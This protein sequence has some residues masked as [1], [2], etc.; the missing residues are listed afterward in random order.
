[1]KILHYALGFP[2]ERT[3]GLV[4]YSLDLINSQI[5]NGHEV[6]LMYPGRLNLFHKK[7]YL[8]FGERN[9]IA[10]VELINSLPL[11]LIGNIGNP[12]DFM[13]SMDN[14]LFLKLLNNI[15]PDVIHIHTLMGLYSEFLEIAKKLNI[16]IV[17]TTHDYF[18]I[19]PQPKFYLSNHDF[20]DDDQYDIWNN[21]QQYGSGT[22]KLRVS[23]LGIYPVLRFLTKFSKKIVAIDLS[24]PKTVEWIKKENR[25]FQN[26]K[27]Y[28]LNMLQKVDIIH[29][30]SSISKQVYSQFLPQ[31]GWKERV[32]PIS[33]D[34]IYQS[35]EIKLLSKKIKTV[36]Y[37]GPYTEEKGF[38]D[39]LDFVK[40]I[41][42]ENS[43]I[44]FIIMGDDSRVDVSGI[45]N[46]GKYNYSK[47]KK[48]LKN[49]DLVILPSKWHE[50]FGLVAT[51][52]IS[53]ET[54]VIVSKKMGAID[55]VPE[56]L[57][58]DNVEEI[59]IS[60]L[61]KRSDKLY[62]ISAQEHFK[63]ITQIYTE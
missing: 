46:L 19:S 28:Y 10:Y 29:F 55:I 47:F 41:A 62:L 23:Q 34:N 12:K 54:K 24:R 14:D 25:E 45:A 16:K 50:T 6:V 18:G 63:R 3:G 33:S 17:F 59:K 43:L 8:K 56:W 20:V 5:K 37:I 30:N 11:P 27:K 58:I 57:Q 1:M 22:A 51:E 61:E 36:A 39:F 40:R 13:K 38:I 26:L 49:I 52:V 44:N 42:I 4:K 31:M 35:G 7:A 53:T 48:Q 9:S 32:I 60:D 21:T 2:P 15:K